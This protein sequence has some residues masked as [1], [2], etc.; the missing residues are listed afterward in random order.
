M[1]WRP[2]L[3]Y[4]ECGLVRARGGLR[5][6][7]RPPSRACPAGRPTSAGGLRQRRLEQGRGL[8]QVGLH[9]AGQLG[10]QHLAG[11]QVGELADLGRRMALPSNTPPL[12]TSSG[13][14]FA[15][16]RR[17]FAASTT[18]P[19]TKASAVGPVNSSS[20]PVDARVRRG[21]LGQRVLGDRVG[22]RRRP[23]SAAAA[24]SCAT[25]RPR[26]SVSTVA[27]ELRKL[28]GEL[29][30][31]G[32]LV[33]PNRLVRHVPP[34]SLLEAGRPRAADNEKRPGAGRTGRAGA[35]QRPSR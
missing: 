17:P 7:R 25:V 3:G 10:Q 31:G 15:N 27:V 35:W 30:D 20:R 5:R 4:G 26:Y 24:V 19:E 34:L 8:A 23:A 12:M 32:G 11:L 1:V 28:L 33:G 29:G 6:P 18:S 2:F 22:R 16:S 9:R 13:L 14:A 21:T